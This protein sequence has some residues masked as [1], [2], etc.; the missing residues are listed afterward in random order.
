MIFCEL[1]NVRIISDIDFFGCQKY[2]HGKNILIIFAPFLKHPGCQ[3]TP[4]LGFELPKIGEVVPAL[5]AYPT[6]LLFTSI[7]SD[8]EINF[9]NCVSWSVIIFRLI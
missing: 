1:F 7:L 5:G 9:F 3:R 4:F 8:E 6:T 2:L